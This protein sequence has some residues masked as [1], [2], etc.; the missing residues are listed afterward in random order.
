VTDY[1]YYNSHNGG[2]YYDAQGSHTAT[3]AVEIAVIGVNS[4]PETLS[5]GDFKLLA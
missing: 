2:L 1:L 5:E 4:H 3:A